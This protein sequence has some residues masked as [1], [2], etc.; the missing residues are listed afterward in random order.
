MR[1]PGLL[2]R[3]FFALLVLWLGLWL[4]S[5]TLGGAIHLVLVAAVLVMLACVISSNRTH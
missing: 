2:W 1:N 3:I 4:A 5:V